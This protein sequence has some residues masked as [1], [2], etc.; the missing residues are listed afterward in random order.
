MTK[1]EIYD[2]VCAHLAKQGRPA[3]L[4]SSCVYYDTTTDEQCAVGCLLNKD[5]ALSYHGDVMDVYGEFELKGTRRP[6]W[7]P[8][9]MGIDE[10]L[11]FLGDL[12]VAHDRVIMD[13][14]TQNLFVSE[15]HRLEKATSQYEAIPISAA[16]M[17]HR[18][19]TI[20]L[21]NG[22]TPGAEDAINEWDDR[23]KDRRP[24]FELSA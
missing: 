6:Y 2:K 13:V 23:T 22:I 12:Q 18:L 4:H 7:V 5:D 16:V 11:S 17:R 8:S 9:D 20:A 15:R 24:P 10:G 21:N 3:I 14:N 1:Q 19:K